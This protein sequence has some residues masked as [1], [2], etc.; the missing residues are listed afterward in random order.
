[1]TPEEK[2]RGEQ[3]WAQR[4]RERERRA[5][6]EEARDVE[7]LFSIKPIRV[8]MGG[9]EWLIP[10]N[11]F[12][13]KGRDKPDSLDLDYFGFHLFLP[14][15]RGFD[16]ENW[17]D[18]F[19]SRQIH[20]FDVSSVDKT[21][22]IPASGGGTKLITP[23]Q[24]GDPQAQFA[25]SRSSLEAHPSLRANGLVGYR[26]LNPD[27]PIVWTGTR[28]N[29]EF[30]F[31]SATLAPGERPSPGRSNPLCQADYYSEKE[32]LRVAYRYSQQN[33]AKWL[34]IDGAIWAKLHQ[35]RVK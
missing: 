14:D 29:G 2:Y 16:K 22:M 3:E 18:P 31:F 35:W 27:S 19:D 11:Y 24:Y 4:A 17:R 30:F 21:Q 8:R 13:P 10:A 28:S 33:F 34:A 1:M 23:A 32:D 20:V 15:Y 26:D 9:R 25:N 12:G 5:E 6:E 7:R